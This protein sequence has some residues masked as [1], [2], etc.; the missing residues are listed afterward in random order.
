MEINSI[1]LLTEHVYLPLSISSG[2]WSWNCWM[3]SWNLSSSMRLLNWADDSSEPRVIFC[4]EVA[5]VSQ[6]KTLTNPQQTLSVIL[7]LPAKICWILH[8]RVLGARAEYLN[9]LRKL[10]DSTVLFIRR[11]NIVWWSSTPPTKMTQ[12]L[13]Y[14]LHSNLKNTANEFVGSLLQMHVFTSINLALIHYNRKPYT[15]YFDHF[16]PPSWSLFKRNVLI[17]Y[18][19]YLSVFSSSR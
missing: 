1:S 18:R 11:P 8:A 17:G 19:P 4:N 6:R 5:L 14:S 9:A 2:L 13:K 3:Y 15:S 16:R 7:K 10:L 12:R